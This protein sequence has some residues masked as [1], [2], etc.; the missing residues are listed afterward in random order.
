MQVAGADAFRDIPG[1]RLL[2]G[3]RGKDD[4]FTLTA[5]GTGPV[6]A[7]PGPPHGHKTAGIPTT[8]Q[9]LRAGSRLRTVAAASGCAR[10]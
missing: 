7:R 4:I 3:L 2:T 1:D 10:S 5:Y 6:P 8:R 9:L